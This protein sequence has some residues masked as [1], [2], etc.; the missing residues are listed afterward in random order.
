MKEEVSSLQIK[1]KWA[2]NKLKTE[3]E[4]HKVHSV[5]GCD[6]QFKR[7][8]TKAVMMTEISDVYLVPLYHNCNFLVGN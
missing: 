7:T 3:T 6:Y 4:A 1:V 2:Q 8:F 5:Y